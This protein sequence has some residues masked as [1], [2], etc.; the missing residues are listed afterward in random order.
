M[1]ACDCHVCRSPDPRDK[2]LRS[3]IQV[4]TPEM[5]IQVD[6][7][8]DFRTQ[9]LREA[10]TRIDAVI[11]THSHTDHI[12]GF[13]DLRRFCELEDKSMP[14]Y[15][16][17]H[18]MEDLRRVYQYAFEGEFRYKNYIRPE[19]NI[20]NGPFQLGET[21]ITPT[22]LPHGRTTTNGLVFSRAGRKLLAYFTDC[23]AVPPEAEKAARGAEILVIDAL[24]R[25]PH[26]TH[27]S[28]EQALEIS[29]RI[30]PEMTYFTHLCHDLGHEETEA[31]LPENV[32]L[33][34]DGL[35]IT[36]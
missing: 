9:C 16:S 8:P 32:R 29:R 4:R 33:A 6:T 27:L 3:S 2:R 10:V 5:I 31:A 25:A 18:T 20:I 21:L 24:R 34:Y 12:L 36:V 7:T 22:V 1:I 23:G 30:A 14:V 19:P 13:D 11:Y 17:P 35:R 15:A 28:V 26:P